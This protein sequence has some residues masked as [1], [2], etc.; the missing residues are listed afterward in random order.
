VSTGAA[1]ALV[2]R[3][4]RE[5]VRESPSK[6]TADP[7]VD[8]NGPVFRDD[9]VIRGGGL[10]SDLRTLRADFRYRGRLPKRR[11]RLSLRPVG[12]VTREQAVG[13]AFAEK[14]RKID[15]DP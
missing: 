6:Y 15:L 8:P 10:Q 9:H 12:A 1:G 2:L 5:W 7:M 11:L 4:A 13:P 3:G 14:D